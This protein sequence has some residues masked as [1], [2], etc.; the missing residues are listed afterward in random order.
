MSEEEVSSLEAKA[1]LVVD[2]VRA[3]RSRREFIMVVL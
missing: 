1:R 2:V 3:R